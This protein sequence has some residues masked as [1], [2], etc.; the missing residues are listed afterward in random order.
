MEALAALR[1]LCESVSEFTEKGISG[2]TTLIWIMHIVL[3]K[4]PAYI[5]R[6]NLSIYAGNETM[7]TKITTEDKPDQLISGEYL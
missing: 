4:S 2:M 3:I 7:P 6:N 1:G 5:K